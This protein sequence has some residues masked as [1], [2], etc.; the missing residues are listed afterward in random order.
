MSDTTRKH[1]TRR[2]ELR[3]TRIYTPPPLRGVAENLFALQ[4]DLEIARKIQERLLPACPEVPGYDFGVFYQPAGQVGGD[5]Y[6][7]MPGDDG[8]VGL[9][10]ADAS[11]KGLAGALLMVEARAMIRAMATMSTSPR[12]ILT[13]V[14]RVLLHDLEKGMFVTV[15]LAVLDSDRRTLT[16]A[17]AGHTPAL[18]WRATTGRVET[19]RP[20]GLVLG[21]AG[22]AAFGR[23]I[24]EEKT[25]LGP[26][27]R[28]LIYSDGVSELMNPVREEFGME[29]LEKW[30]EGN[31]HLSSPDVIR[32]LAAVLEAHR[33]GQEQ[34]DDIT[35]LTGQVA[36]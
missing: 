2:K 33:A 20:R 9:L 1:A 27:D 29:R 22:D 3:T 25:D 31:G 11:G 32:G 34:S 7:F 12:E 23:A 5:F 16:V 10:V 8:H 21:A 17:N 19:L 4:Q 24:V 18:L 13:S 26:G 30:L 14:N 28:F 6:D 36:F 15:F 35:I